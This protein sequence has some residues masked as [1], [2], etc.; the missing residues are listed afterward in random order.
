MYVR[1]IADSTLSPCHRPRLYFGLGALLIAIFCVAGLFAGYRMG[2]NRGYVA[3]EEQRAAERLITRVYSVADLVDA[4][5]DEVEDYD[6][7]IELI[8]T[9]IDQNTWDDV[10]GPGSIKEFSNNSIV[11]ITQTADTHV[12]I[13]KLLK[14]LRAIP[15]NERPRVRDQRSGLAASVGDATG[16]LIHRTSPRATVRMR[17]VT[18]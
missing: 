18:P 10:G 15:R 16:R 1:V 5:P 6:S 9:A 8:T 4:G 13:E 12:E 17:K 2:V 11:V 14:N 7:L 3:G